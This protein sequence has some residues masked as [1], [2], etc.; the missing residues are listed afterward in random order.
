MG[1]ASTRFCEEKV[2]AVQDR[3]RGERDSRYKIL[4]GEGVRG[5]RQIER[6]RGQ[7]YKILRGQGVRGTRH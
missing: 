6:R 3:L 2:A 4:R 1:T 5:T 7:R